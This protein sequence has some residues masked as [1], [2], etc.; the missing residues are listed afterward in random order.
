MSQSRVS[1]LER[2][3]ERSEKEHGDRSTSRLVSGGARG[4]SLR[5]SEERFLVAERLR[6]EVDLLR[7]AKL[8][9]EG[10]LLDRDAQLVELRF[11]LEARE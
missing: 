3:R 7:R 10:G 2:E 11:D 8:E 4:A 9:L 6:G 1:E 5:E